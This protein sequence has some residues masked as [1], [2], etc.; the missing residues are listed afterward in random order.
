MSI[1]TCVRSASLGN[2][3]GAPVV[4]VCCVLVIA[5]AATLRF[6]PA[7]RPLAV[8]LLVGGALLA[9]VRQFAATELISGLVPA[10]PILVA[11]LVFLRRDD[12]RRPVVRLCLGVSAISALGI[13][14]TSYTVGG[15]VE[16]GGR[17]YHLLHPLVVPIVV[18]GLDR[19]RRGLPA[20][21]RHIAVVSVLVVTA[22][23]SLLSLRAMHD[24]RRASEIVVPAALAAADA[25][26]AP[27]D[28]G[29]PV[30]I[31]DAEPLARSAWASLD[32]YRLLRVPDSADLEPLLDILADEQV[33][34][35]TVLV[36]PLQELPDGSLGR[37]S[38]VE[39]RE[40]EGWNISCVELAQR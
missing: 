4:L 37:W 24:M 29:A 36:S 27:S 9:V 20:G 40:L 25:A 26:A 1:C 32:G 33:G 22:S 19:A 11:G 10:F 7:R 16:W 23:L 13:W 39:E 38:V 31:T 34:T 35:V 8:G 6:L 2:G 21:P 28:G 12:L 17:F 3:W 30:L 14:A 5:G 18:L 15:G